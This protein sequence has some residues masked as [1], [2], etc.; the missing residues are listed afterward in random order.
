MSISQFAE[1][2]GIH[3]G[4][5]SNMLHGR[6]PIAMQQLDRVTRAMGLAEGYYYDLYIDNY[7]VDGSSD[8]RRVGPLLQR[9]AELG[10]LD[11]IHRVVRIVTDKLQYLPA[12]F[13]TAEE[14]YAQG[15]S[16]AA[17]LLYECVAESEKYQ[18][19]ERLAL[20][21]Y[22]L[23]RIGLCE[24][25]D[26]NLRLA[27]QF[28]SYVERLDEADQL[29][30]LKHLADVFASRHRWDKVDEMAER[31]GQKSDIYY[32]YWNKNKNQKQPT[33]PLIYY[34]LYAYLLKSL[35]CD[36]CGDYQKAIYY[37]SLY[38]DI[39]W[40][41]NPVSEEESRVIEQF[42]EWGT[43]NT[44]L[45][46]LMS[47]ELEVLPEYVNYVESRENEIF[48]ALF[49]IMQAANRYEANVD[50][51]LLKFNSHLSCRE[52]HSRLGKFNQQITDDRYTHLHIELATYYLGHERFEIGFY[53]LMDSLESSVRMRNDYN[54]VRCVGLFEKYRSVALQEQTSLYKKLYDSW[55]WGLSREY[56]FHDN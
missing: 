29:D 42:K 40:I 25:Q 53:Y 17:A 1:R 8:W 33:R 22:R 15:N 46:R 36:E 51:I 35:V 54:I 30:A 41:E 4:T 20:C 27:N 12:L 28:E 9:C 21:Q 10:K 31:L 39:N 48:P 50:D 13:D 18:H 44:Y 26:E 24:D 7:I 56:P 43:A 49:K 5:L 52:Q 14:L 55:C 23:F 45:Y 3:S 19:S 32:K 37:A 6:R 11:S 47:G 2:S 38:V 16:A 34:I